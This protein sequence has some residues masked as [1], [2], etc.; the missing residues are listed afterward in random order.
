[1]QTIEANGKSPHEL[2][3]LARV[4]GNEQ[5][6]LSKAMAH[7]LLN[8]GFSA[9]DKARMHELAV[10]NQNGA[11]SPGEKGELLAYAKAGTLLSILKSKAR[12]VLRTK[13]KKPT[14]R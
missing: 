2:A 11:L 4:L 12:R 1:M 5:G 10:G 8:V 13:A 14:T 3:I 7:L 6:Q 9:Y